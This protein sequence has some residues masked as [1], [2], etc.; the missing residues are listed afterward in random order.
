[1]RHRVEVWEPPYPPTK[2]QR[3]PKEEA[4]Y[5]AGVEM[6]AARSKIVDTLTKMGVSKFGN[7]EISKVTRL[8][9]MAVE[10]EVMEEFVGGL[11]KFAECRRKFMGAQ[12]GD[13]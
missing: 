10:S 2:S 1:M 6:A 12:R 5:V 7:S 8:V 9:E 4:V 11:E 13:K 3:T